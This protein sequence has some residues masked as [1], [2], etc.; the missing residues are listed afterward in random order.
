[1][2]RK[3]LE[4]ERLSLFLFLTIWILY[5]TIYMTKNC[6]SAAMA[7]LVN[8]QVLTKSQTGAINAAFYLIYAIFQV[9]GGI[10]VDRF[11]PGKIVFIGF[12]GAAACNAVVYYN[13][14]YTVMLIAW[15]M[16]AV[17]QFGVWPGIFKIISSQLAPVHR[18]KG[19]FYIS[20]A[21]SFGLIVSYIC[22][23]LVS[24]WQS[25]FSISA[26]SLFVASVIWIIMYQYVE[27][28]MVT[29]D[30]EKSVKREQ[31]SSVSFFKLIL[32]S[33]AILLMIS[34]LIQSVINCGLKALTPVM[35]MESYESISPS[36]ANSLNI[37]LIGGGVIASFVARKYVLNRFEN[38]A[39]C[40]S[41]FYALCVPFVVLFVFV[42]KIPAVIL[43]IALTL[44]VSLMTVGSLTVFYM[45]ARFAKYGYDGTASGVFN[46]MAALGIVVAN[47]VFT[48]LADSFGWAV[49]NYVWIGTTMF[50][51]IATAAAIPLWRK[52]LKD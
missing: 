39:I 31:K 21:N 46:A 30:V 34:N 18:K 38:E 23:A 19:V 29:V 27:K 11:S 45:T 36:L 24:R 9:V 35:L 51:L 33:G 12:L 28:K 3:Y 17:V 13:Q 48:R 16:N 14:N 20:L 7:D 50:G 41:L 26:I 37:L 32:F 1:M 40:M 43:F 25:N 52:M 2:K 6:Y 44:V 10:A 47:F 8:E 22:A 4:N 42:G 5:T 49:T 15:S